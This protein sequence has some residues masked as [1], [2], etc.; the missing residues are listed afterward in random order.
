V[1]YNKR[2]Q[3]NKNMIRVKL[4]LL[5]L[6]FSVF[7]CVG[8][9]AIPDSTAI[10]LGYPVYSQYLQN[11]LVINP[12]YTGSRGALSAFISYRAQW[13]KTPGSPTNQSVSFHTPMKNDKV[14]LGILAQFQQYGFSRNSSIYA[15]YAYHIRMGHGKLSLGLKG[16]A[17]MSNTNFSGKMILTQDGDEAFMTNEK[18]YV[19]P[20]TG[21]GIYYFSEKFFIGA[22]VPQFLSYKRTASGGVQAYH[23]FNNYDFIFSAGGLITFSKAFKFKP[24]VLVDYSLQ[25]TRNLTQLDLNANFIL[26][27]LVWIGGS[28]RTTEEVAV[29]IFQLQL[30]Q[31]L[32]IG[33]SYDYSVGTMNTFSKGSTEFIIRYEFGS[34]VSAANP[35]YF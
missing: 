17:D 1:V 35:R 4:I 9:K 8:G 25:N 13:M 34:K 32:M 33:A 30:N 26:G 10:T 23:E 14:A 15:S 12:A 5:L 2:S 11:G 6:G 16:G 27:D 21:A 7:F 18:P 22:S 29:G 31:Q 3:E 24:S 28:W 20:N 19:L